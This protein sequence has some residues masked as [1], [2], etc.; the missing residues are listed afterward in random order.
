MWASKCLIIQTKFYKVSFV[1]SA[2]RGCNS[3]VRGLGNETSTLF[4]S[5]CTISPDNIRVS[6]AHKRLCK[7]PVRPPP[8]LFTF[9]WPWC[10]FRGFYELHRGGWGFLSPS[11]CLRYAALNLL[12][13]FLPSSA[14]GLFAAPKQE[15][16]Q[17]RLFRKGMIKWQK[18][19]VRA[20]LHLINTHRKKRKII[21]GNRWRNT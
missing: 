21:R 13:F 12:L 3:K 2:R 15:R 11:T 18:T 8:E 19:T 10:T 4:L 1:G 20:G 5:I 9:C 6:L 7:E 16:T 14:A 17:K